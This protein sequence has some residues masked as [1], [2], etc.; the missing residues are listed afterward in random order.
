MFIISKRDEYHLSFIMCERERV[1]YILIMV[2]FPKFYFTKGRE[3]VHEW[4]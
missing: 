2:R 1:Y 3:L 4:V